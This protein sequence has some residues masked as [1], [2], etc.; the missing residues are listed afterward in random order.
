MQT[1]DYE[2]PYFVAT[3]TEDGLENVHEF[4]MHAEAEAYAMGFSEGCGHYGG[5]YGM[6]FV[7]PNDVDDLREAL[8]EDEDLEKILA[9]LR[10]RGVPLP[11]E[12][13]KP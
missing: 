5:D 9:T 3:F 2:G 13:P 1:V 4:G 7:L 12:E 10:Q 11:G 8:E 6:A